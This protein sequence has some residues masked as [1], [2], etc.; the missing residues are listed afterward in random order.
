MKRAFFLLGLAMAWS[1][2]FAQTVEVESDT[3]S[4]SIGTPILDKSDKQAIPLSDVDMNIPQTKVLSDKTFVVIIANEKYQHEQSVPFAVHDGEIFK[5]YCIQTLGI[6]EKNIQFLQCGDGLVDR[7]LRR[8]RDLFDGGGDARALRHGGVDGGLDAAPGE[9]VRVV[10]D[11]V[12]EDEVEH[13]DGFLVADVFA[14]Q[15]DIVVGGRQVVERVCRHRFE[16]EADLFGIFCS[17]CA[18]IGDLVAVGKR[19]ATDFQIGEAAAF[20]VCGDF[21]YSCCKCI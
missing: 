21:E 1:L 18:Q 19:T 12:R 2:G 9:D 3:Y 13:F 17:I 8:L 7:L 14:R 6:P 15:A 10:H 4:F 20:G 5:Q 11:D 16:H